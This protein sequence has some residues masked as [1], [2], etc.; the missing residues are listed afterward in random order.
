VAVLINNLF[1]AYKSFIVKDLLTC[2]CTGEDRFSSD[3][4]QTPDPFGVRMDKVD[5]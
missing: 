3:L 4:W 2:D 5:V 1:L